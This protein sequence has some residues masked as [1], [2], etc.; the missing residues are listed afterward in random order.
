MPGKSSVVIGRC[1]IP[2]GCIVIEITKFNPK[3]CR[4][5]T[6]ET[7]IHADRIMNVLDRL[8]VVRDHP[9]LCSECIIIGEKCT[10]IAIAT[11]VLGREKRSTSDCPN[12]TGS[13]S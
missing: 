8:S 2:C 4:L 12:G 1:F 9:D 7:R 5:D 13:F 11:K 3:N 10:P 6:V